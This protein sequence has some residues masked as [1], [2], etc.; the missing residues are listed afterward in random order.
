MFH[1]VSHVVFKTTFKNSHEKPDSEWLAGIKAGQ[2]DSRIT[3]LTCSQCLP[4]G[5]G[6][7]L[8]KSLLT[9]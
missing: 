2:Y 7:A 4:K 6:S 5:R 3:P 1:I 8:T 9:I